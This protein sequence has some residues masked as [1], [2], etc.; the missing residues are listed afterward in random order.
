MATETIVG[1]II[2][3][4][5]QPRALTILSST[6]TILFHR[7]VL[8]SLLIWSVLGPDIFLYTSDM[9]NLWFDLKVRDKVLHPYKKS[10]NIIFLI[11]FI[12]I[13]LTSYCFTENC[14][15]N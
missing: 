3:T 2:A 7:E 13:I 15:P 5:Y 6:I 12:I 9:G 8:N 14:F 4:F 10:D 11:C 1:R